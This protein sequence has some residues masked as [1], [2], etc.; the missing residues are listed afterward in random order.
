MS[1]SFYPPLAAP[2]RLLF[3]PGPSMVAPRVYEAMRQPVVGHL[4]PFFFQVADEIRMLLG[5]VFSTANQYNIAISG[6][7]SSGME[8]AVANLTEPGD[9]FALLTNGFFGDRIGE[10]AARH[11][12]QVVKLAKPWG[13][14]FDPQ[15]A[16]EFIRRERPRVVAFVQAETSTGMFNRAKPISE[17]AH[18]VD[19]L[20]IADC[21]TSLGG[22]PV[23][24]DD[25]GIDIAYSCSQ[26]GLGCPP[27][28][29]PITV[30]PRALERV[31]ARKTPVHSFYLDFQLLD[32][33]YAGHKYHHTASATAFYALREGLAMVAEETLEARW[34]RHRLNHEAFVAGIKAMGL[35]MHVPEGHRLWTLNTPRV[36]DGVDD[37]KVRS[38]LLEHRNMEIAGGFGP[39]A[40]KVFR[41]GTMGYGSTPE[42][43]HLI[44][45]SLAA[46]LKHAGYA[47]AIA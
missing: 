31:K 20:V 19:A 35:S 28:L 22:M 46:A 37:A 39:L 15:E 7:G 26:K 3:G 33:F 2:P 45:E 47:A 42:N 44:L 1:Q 13:E 21:V 29:A 12:G 32:S 40:G 16:R 41:I 34:E 25:N 17:A 6:T 18:E 43:V 9:K 30:S 24:V 8:A 27:G 5:Y 38:W 14:P 36:P 11:G 4:D 10:M 23:L